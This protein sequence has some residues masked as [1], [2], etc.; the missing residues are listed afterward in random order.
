MSALQVLIG[1]WAFVAL[2]AVLFIRGASARLEQ[3]VERP[4]KSKPTR[5]SRFGI[6][7]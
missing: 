7:E 1:I 5:R 3:P 4:A 6:A 2:G